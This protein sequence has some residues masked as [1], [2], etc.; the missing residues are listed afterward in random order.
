[1]KDLVRA[2]RATAEI[3]DALD[4]LSQRSFPAAERLSAA[5]DS[6]SE[7]LRTLPFMGRARDERWPG[8]RSVVVGDYLLFYRVTDTEVVVVRFIHGSRDL[9]TALDDAE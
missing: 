8:Y 9:A 6:K 2:D 3:R 1:M 4:Y 7:L 5:I